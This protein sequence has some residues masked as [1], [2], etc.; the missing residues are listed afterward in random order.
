M[1]QPAIAHKEEL[2]KLWIEHLN[3]DR[4][5][6]TQACSYY[7]YDLDI[8]KDE[9][10]YMQLVSIENEK[11]VGYVHVGIN[12]EHDRVSNILFVS[13][14]DKSVTFSL[15]C[16]GVFENL[17]SRF[18]KISFTCVVGNPAEKMYN[19]LVKRY[20]GRVACVQKDHI[21]LRDGKYYDYKLYEIMCK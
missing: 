14:V 10:N 1:I 9:W 20:N 18:R 13:F 2:Q 4:S 12:R 5:M 11:I 15:D 3:S 8:K 7:E 21:R 16:K 19:K 17:M 6:Y